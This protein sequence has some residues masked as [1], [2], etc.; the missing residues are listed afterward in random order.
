[1]TTLDAYRTNV[2]SQNGEDGVLAEIFQRLTIE[3]GFFVEFGAWDG[4][5]LSNTYRLAELG[6]NGLY[7]E[8]DA[9]R[10]TELRANIAPFEGR[11]AAQQAWVQATGPDSLDAVLARNSVP[12]EPELLSI[13]I[14]S[15]D[16]NIFRHVSD[17]RPVVVILEINSAIP[18]GIVQTHRDSEV[19]GSSFSAALMLARAKGYALVCHTGNVIL[20]RMDRVR[21]LS[22]PQDELDFPELLFDYS[23]IVRMR[24]AAAAPPPVGLRTALRTLARRSSS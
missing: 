8:G 15:D 5:H 10:F 12:A 7:L 3:H 13:D 11:V 19:Q 9:D 24:R 18:P 2:Y 21:E 14:D 16:W 20:V 1:M 22:L 23:G 4:K 17:H 6:W